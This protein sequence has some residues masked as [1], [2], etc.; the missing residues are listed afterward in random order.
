LQIQYSRKI[1]PVFNENDPHWE[2]NILNPPDIIS[3]DETDL[4]IEIEPN[5]NPKL[6]HPEG[7]NSAKTTMQSL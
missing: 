5:P 7:C 3:S 4:D 1:S 2:E 6:G